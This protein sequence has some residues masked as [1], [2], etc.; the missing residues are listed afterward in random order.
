MFSTRQV[1]CCGRVVTSVIGST[2]SPLAS[3]DKNR[4]RTLPRD[5][6]TFPYRTCLGTEVSETQ[7][8]CK[9]Q[10]T[11]KR[12]RLALERWFAAMNNLSDASLLAPY[13]LM[14]LA[15]LSVDSATTYEAKKR[16][17]GARRQKPS[18]PTFSTLF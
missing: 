16:G 11:A 10:T 15:A 17:G 1:P 3:S 14:G 13:K 9:G 6:R 8:K 18:G 7:G 12:V 4:G 2:V 5:P